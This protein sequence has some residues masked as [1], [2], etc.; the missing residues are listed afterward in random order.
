MLI[1]SVIDLAAVIFAATNKNSL[2]TELKKGFDKI[3]FKDHEKFNAVQE[4]F[5]CCAPTKTVTDPEWKKWCEK[6]RP[7]YANKVHIFPY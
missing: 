6:N 3:E 5:E 1:L 4:V 7:E 2:K